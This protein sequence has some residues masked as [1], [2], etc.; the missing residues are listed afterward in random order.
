M[1]SQAKIEPGTYVNPDPLETHPKTGAA[2]L[3]EIRETVKEIIVPM[4]VQ[5]E[6]PLAPIP[7]AEKPPLFAGRGDDELLG[8]GV[9]PE[10][11]ADVKTANEDT[12]L[13]LAD[14]LP[15]CARG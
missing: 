13:L 1:D 14:H 10:W 7:F 3:V 6:L 15:S 5:S 8:Y 2:Q 11:L 12:L 9:P 4:Y